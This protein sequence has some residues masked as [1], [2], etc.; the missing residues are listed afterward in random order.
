MGIV[1]ELVLS[2]GPSRR[3][4]EF[5][6]EKKAPVGLINSCTVHIFPVLGA[7]EKIDLEEGHKTDR[8]HRA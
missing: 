7:A 8:F 2:V 6:E 4:L 1:A 5:L 3:G